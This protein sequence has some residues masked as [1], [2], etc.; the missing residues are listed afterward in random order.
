MP[1]IDQKQRDKY[2]IQHRFKKFTD[3][4]PEIETKGDLEYLVFR[5]MKKFMKTREKR[6]STL[7]DCVYAVQHCSDEFR[8]LYLDKREDEAMKKNGDIE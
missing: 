7:H 6:Y 8:R 2:D 3:L 5:L 4:L 1:Y